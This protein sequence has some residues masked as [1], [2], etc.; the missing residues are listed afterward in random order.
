[1][2]WICKERF[3]LSV[4]RIDRDRTL[5]EDVCENGTLG[6]MSERMKR[7]DVRDKPHGQE[8][9]DPPTYIGHNSITAHCL[10]LSQPLVE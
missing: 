7:H 10:S 6:L 1:M 4:E 2:E 3:R 9:A 5:T 8:D